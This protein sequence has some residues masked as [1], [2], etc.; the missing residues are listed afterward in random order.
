MKLILA[1]S[2]GFCFGVRRA[3][4]LCEQAAGKSARC[5][6]L[7]PIIH[8]ASVTGKLASLVCARGGRSVGD[9]PRRHGDH[10]VARRQ[11]VGH[12]STRQ[13]GR[14]RYRRHLPDVAKIH[15]IVSAESDAGRKIIIIGER[16]HLK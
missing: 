4:R 10:P 12:S 14:G 7:G 11:S 2:A 15:K 1:K 16:T 5:V 3:V 9:P 6:T 8:N 13:N